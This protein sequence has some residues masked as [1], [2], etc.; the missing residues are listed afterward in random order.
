MR[1]IHPTRLT[2]LSPPQP[3]NLPPASLPPIKHLSSNM[4]RGHPQKTQI[5]I[6][7]LFILNDLQS[8]NIHNLFSH[9]RTTPPV[10]LKARIDGLFFRAKPVRLRGEHI[11]SYPQVIHNPAKPIK[12]RRLWDF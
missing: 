9:Q 8:K 2:A 10:P 4:P 3:P 1:F 11:N 6:H 5:K 7:K 12:S